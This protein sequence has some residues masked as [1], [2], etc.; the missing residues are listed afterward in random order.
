MNGMCGITKK[1]G[2]CDP[3]KYFIDGTGVYVANSLVLDG[4]RSARFF[5]LV[6]ETRIFQCLRCSW[7]D[8]AR[9]DDIKSVPSL[10]PDRSLLVSM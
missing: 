1:N 8:C 9:R 4:R 3:R 10:V 6:K 7:S 5:Y 2:G